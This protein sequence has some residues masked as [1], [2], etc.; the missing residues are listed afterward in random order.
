LT[1]LTRAH[2]ESQV[3]RTLEADISG[4]QIIQRRW[5]IPR[6]PKKAD[7]KAGIVRVRTTV[8]MPM[9]SYITVTIGFTDEPQPNP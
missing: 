7:K 4:C 6:K 1:P 2:I 3:Q 5:R 9:L 8:Q